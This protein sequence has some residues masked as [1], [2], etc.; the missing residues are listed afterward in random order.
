MGCAENAPVT[1]V[2]N[3][4]GRKESAVSVAAR[5]SRGEQVLA[6]DLAFFGNAWREVPVPEY[7]QIVHGLGE[8]PLGI[9]VGQLLEI[10]RWLRDR[11]GGARVRVESAGLRQQVVVLAAAAFEPDLFSEITIHDGLKTLSSLLERPVSFSQA[12]ELFCLDFF[13]Y[14][15]LDRLQAM[16]EGVRVESERPWGPPK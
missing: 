10:T 6:L 1:L 11:A 16:A 2:L 13:K 3:D 5:V 14:F 15:D 9:M 7:A 8:R 12:P 4:E